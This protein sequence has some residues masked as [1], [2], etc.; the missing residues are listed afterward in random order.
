MSYAD[1]IFSCQHRTALYQL[2]VNGLHFRLLRWDRSGVIVSKARAYA[3]CLDDTKDFLRILHRYSQMTNEERGMDPTAVRL[4]K[5]SWGWARMEAVGVCMVHDVD[6]KPGELHA[7]AIPPNFPSVLA[8]PP[9]SSLITSGLLPADPT[10][11]CAD[12]HD[13]IASSDILPTFKFIREFFIKSLVDNWPRYMIT[14][15]GRKYLAAKPHFPSQDSE[16]AGMVSR[17]TRGYVALEWESQRFMYLK[18]AWRPYYAGV[19]SEGVTLGKLNAAPVCN[20]PTCVGYEDVGSRE[21]RHADGTKTLVGGQE[22]E[23]SKYA[24]HVRRKL[25]RKITNDRKAPSKNTRSRVV[26]SL[27]KRNATG[28]RSKGGNHVLLT[29]PAPAIT[30]RSASGAVAP[31]TAPRTASCGTKRPASETEGA[32]DGGA[33]Q[34]PGSACR[35]MI[36]HRVVV[37]EVCLDSTQFT[38]AKQWVMIVGCCVA[39][40]RHTVSTRLIDGVLILPCHIAHEEAVKKCDL[41]HR[42]I[43]VGNILILPEIRQKGSPPLFG[44]GWRGILSD[45]ELAKAQS[46]WIVRQPV[47]TVSC[48]HLNHTVTITDGLWNIPGYVAVYVFVLLGTPFYARLHPR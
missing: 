5:D 29:A 41:V 47:R 48:A 35:H 7:S 13:P 46:V 45:W 1:R 24:P 36:H 21:E 37:A 42:D 31:P 43:S 44:I 2:F 23:A 39:G 6:Q 3:G 22:T 19:D 8:K 11:P 10:T 12:P 32:E 34:E 14:V 38:S 4:R 15:A 30:P 20:V 9:A 16:S 17:G 40:A 28:T 33:E 27:P 25:V 18:D 26:H